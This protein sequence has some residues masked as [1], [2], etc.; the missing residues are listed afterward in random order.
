VRRE[1]GKSLCGREDA[2][3]SRSVAS[4]PS[5]SRVHGGYDLSSE[6]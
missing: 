3:G 5:G 6:E 4:G 2:G 1:S